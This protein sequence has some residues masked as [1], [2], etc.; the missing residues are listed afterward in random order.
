LYRALAPRLTAL[1]RRQFWD[2]TEDVVH[3]AFLRAFESI[4]SFR[5][6]DDSAR[7][8]GHFLNWLASIGK[9]KGID[10]ARRKRPDTG[11]DLSQSPAKTDVLEAIVVR[12]Q[13]GI[14][15]GCLA[16]L[17]EEART[18][19]ESQYGG[20]EDHSSVCKRLRITIERGYKLRHKAL[21]QLRE[22]AK[23]SKR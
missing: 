12:E 15:E 6:D 9:N 20:A 22:C 5:P 18:L 1:L 8:E 21:E 11:I 4:N 14:L 10:D 3:D 7:I 13:R 2:R 23:R 16:K 19:I 17:D